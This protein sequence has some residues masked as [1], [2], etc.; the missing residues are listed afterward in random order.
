MV[1]QHNMSAMLTECSA[2]FHLHSQSQQRSYLQVTE[3]T[4]QLMMLQ[5]FQSQK[6]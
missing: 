3:L 5:D 6:R 1:V 2:E 4:V